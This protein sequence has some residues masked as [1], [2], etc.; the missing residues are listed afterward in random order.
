MWRS[1]LTLVLTLCGVAGATLTAML[2][3]AQRDF[4]RPGPAALANIAAAVVFTGNFER[5][6]VALHLLANRTVSRLFVS[7]FNAEAGLSPETF[8]EQFATRNPDIANLRDMANCC[9]EYGALA[10]NTLQNGLETRCWAER[11]MESGPLLLITSRAHMA[12]ALLALSTVMRKRTII[13]Y[14]SDE[15]DRAAETYRARA[16]ESLKY[17]AMSLALDAPWLPGRARREGSFLHG[18]QR[19]VARRLPAL[20]K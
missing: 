2:V 9:I 16:M 12:R 17:V 5:I 3:D 18:C 20:Q 7:G 11:E 19:P 6:D 15:P 14:V 10:D 4:G 8:V 1:A 13:P